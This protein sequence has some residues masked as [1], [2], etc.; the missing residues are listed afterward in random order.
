VPTGAKLEILPSL[1]QL[2][3]LQG[4]QTQPAFEPR[5]CSRYVFVICIYII[6]MSCEVI[7]G[8]RTYGCGCQA[9]LTCTCAAISHTHC[10]QAVPVWRLKSWLSRRLIYSTLPGRCTCCSSFSVYPAEFLD[11]I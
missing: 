8:S 2:A 4:S 10:R 6:S 11:A 3:Q 9:L 1:A 7:L 5:L